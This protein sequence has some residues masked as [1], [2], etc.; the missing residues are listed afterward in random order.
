[1]LCKNLS[2][3]LGVDL[4]TIDLEEILKK[5]QEKRWALTIHI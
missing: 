3:Y 4:T 1:M 5:P 2:A